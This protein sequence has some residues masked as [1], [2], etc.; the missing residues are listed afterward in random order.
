MKE[1]GINAGVGAR[2]IEFGS[3]SGISLDRKAR[4]DQTGAVTVEMVLNKNRHGASGRTI[5]VM[6]DGATQRFTEVD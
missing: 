3:E 1:G 2:R 5:T 4:P 6:F